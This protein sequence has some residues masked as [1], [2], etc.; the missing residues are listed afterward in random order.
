MLK[1]SKFF[2]F[3]VTFFYLLA[4]VAHLDARLTSDHEV[5]VRIL[6]GRQH[7][8]VEIDH[9]MFSTFILSLPLIQEG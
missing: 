5:A 8:F 3:S 7:S 1:G 4:S 6:P 2:P 9:E